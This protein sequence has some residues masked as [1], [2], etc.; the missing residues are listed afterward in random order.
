MYMVES[1]TPISGVVSSAH[2]QNDLT[3]ERVSLLQ[4]KFS[5]PPAKWDGLFGLLLHRAATA[6]SGSRLGL[7]RPPP[8]PTQLS[9]ESRDKDRHSPAEF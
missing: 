1:K 8:L 9:A 7:I 5:S 4:A 3:A 2:V 6:G